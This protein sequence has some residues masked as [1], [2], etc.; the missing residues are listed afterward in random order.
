MAATVTVQQQLGGL[1][2]AWVRQILITG[3]TSYVT[4]GYAITAAQLGLALAAPFL[5]LCEPAT[6]S[7]TGAVYLPVFDY[8][9]MK[10]KFYYPQ[11]GAS[12]G[13]NDGTGTVTTGVTAMTG[14]AA[15]LAAINTAPAKEV[16][17][18]RNLSLV[19]CRALVVGA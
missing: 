5:F 3:D 16:Q 1:G 13:T 18:A 2:Q 8:T 17:A 10:L 12:A 9:N 4:G 11:G 7:G 15:T 6:D 14:T 19:T